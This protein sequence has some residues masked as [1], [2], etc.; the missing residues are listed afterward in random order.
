VETTIREQE[1]EQKDKGT[2]HLRACGNYSDKNS[3][4]FVT[5]ATFIIST[6]FVDV[7]VRG[8]VVLYHP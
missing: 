5:L 3:T 4:V 1:Q 7:P 8:I 6:T 2:Y